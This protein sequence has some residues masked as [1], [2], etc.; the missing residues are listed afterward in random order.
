MLMPFEID[1]HD[2]PGKDKSDKDKSS[3]CLSSGEY[4]FSRLI[5][6]QLGVLS[7]S[8]TWSM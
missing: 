8:E 2:P 4:W 3:V 7:L 1:I 5:C 6:P